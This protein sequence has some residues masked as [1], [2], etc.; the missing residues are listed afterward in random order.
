MKIYKRLDPNNPKTNP[1]EK[2]LHLSR[3]QYA[4]KIINK[5]RHNK[6][7]TILDAACGFGY[8]S[9][10][11]QSKTHS[12][13]I[14]VDLDPILVKYLTKTNKKNRKMKFIKSNIKS[15]PFS[16]CS[17]DYVVCFETIEHLEKTD[18]IRAIKEFKRVLKKNGM[19]II[20][21]PNAN[22]TKLI[23]RIFP[24]YNNLFHLHEYQPGELERILKKNKFAVMERRG[25]YLFFPIIYLFAR[26]L[27]FLNFLFMPT[28][29]FPLSISRYFIIVAK[30]I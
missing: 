16:D 24:K 7:I 25:Q 22:L 6:K 23:Q 19:I 29:L 20:S 21:S 11:L 8:G 27:F 30:K 18:G 4:T 5:F 12:N 15:L 1:A 10:I 26:Y 2:I 9:K 14:G 3:Y 17:I 28:K 13:V